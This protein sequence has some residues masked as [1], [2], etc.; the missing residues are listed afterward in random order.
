MISEAKQAYKTKVEGLFKTNKSADAWK[1]LKTL[2]GMLKSKKVPALLNSHGV[3][4]ELNKFYAR[5]DDK[6]F[7][8][9]HQDLNEKL[10]CRSEKLPEELVKLQLSRVKT[11][12][13]PG[14]DRIQGMVI[15]GCRESLFKIIYHIYNESLETGVFP[16]IWKMGAI[17]PVPKKDLP[18]EMNDFRPVTLTSILAKCC[19]RAVRH[20]L[21]QHVE[22]WLDPLQFAYLKNRSTD[23]ATLY[24]T[25]KITKH[26]DIKSSNTARALLI[27]YSSAF[28]LMQPHILI[29]KLNNMDVPTFLQRWILHF[30]IKRP[31][32][33]QT[34]LERSSTLTLSTGAPQGCAL[35]ANL[36]VLYTNDLQSDSEET[37]IIKYA[38][39]TVVV[40]LISD[41]DDS[42][43]F[44]CISKVERWCDTNHLC[45]NINKTKEML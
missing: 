27:D 29:N 11:N 15:K 3:A 25:H 9:E 38:D 41:D 45:L 14:P 19:E 26:L 4:D 39:D 42:K 28:N 34:K 10:Q 33:V 7:S 5:F 24:L 40:G 30:L 23:D 37:C 43:Y 35:S 6:D 21:M 17:V 22:Q 16:D 8:K 36:F 44:E 31:Q 2:T 20:L 1:G 13:A 12:K 32:Y 18:K